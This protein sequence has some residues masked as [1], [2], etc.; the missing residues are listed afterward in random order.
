[1]KIVEERETWIHTHF[2]VD[3]FYITP[4][5]QRL[6]SLRVE[7]ELKQMGIQYGLHYKNAPSQHQAV[8]VLECLPFDPIKARIKHLINETIQEFPSRLRERKNV[9]TKITTE[10]PEP[11]EGRISLQA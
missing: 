10:A 9:V 3:S 4:Q 11:S 6:V 2:V 5:E 8:I 7:P 1:M